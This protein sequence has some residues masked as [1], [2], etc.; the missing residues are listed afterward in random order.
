MADLFSGARR[1]TGDTP[2]DN[3][4]S[5]NP[6]LIGGKTYSVTGVPADAAV[7]Q[8]TEMPILTNG[9]LYSMANY[10]RFVQRQEERV[11]FGDGAQSS[12]TMFSST[13]PIVVTQVLVTLSDECP[14]PVSFRMGIVAQASS[15]PTESLSGADGMI[16]GNETISPGGI[17]SVGTGSSILAVGPPTGAIKYSCS[18]VGN[19]AQDHPW[20][21]VY[22]TYASQGSS[23]A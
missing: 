13:A 4:D 5:G 19:T 9:V 18:Q 20:M 17:L 16:I 3:P 8:R 23:E 1:I 14:V 10:T 22:A 15:L 7:L 6:V 11:R 12:R 21:F 2:S